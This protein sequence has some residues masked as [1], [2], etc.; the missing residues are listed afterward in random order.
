[1]ADDQVKYSD[2]IVEDDAIN[3]L[4]KD[5]DKV[6]GKIAEVK[7]EA[8]GLSREL[9]SV[10]T[11]TREH[12]QATAQQA[13]AAENLRRRTRE[14]ADEQSHL[15]TALEQARKKYKKLNDE[16]LQSIMALRQA[17]KGE[18]QD[19]I[20]AAK[21]ID[22]QAKSY[23]ELYQTYNALKDALNQMTVAERE[24]SEAGK[25]M[26]NRAKEIRDT[27]NNLQ[28]AS[29]DRIGEAQKSLV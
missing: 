29:V 13:S 1:M 10:S 22:I 12:Q 20:N 26:V 19:Q 3:N 11:A 18:S 5:L 24:N 27:M 7:Q 8:A 15:E 28:S 17:L 4:L 9:G 23:N 16:E 21:A 2:L 6:K 25:V 14:L